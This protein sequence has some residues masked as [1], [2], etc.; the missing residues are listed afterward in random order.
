M[1]PEKT[2]HAIASILRNVDLTDLAD[3]ILSR[4]HLKRRRPAMTALSAI[5][6]MGLGAA[7]A[8]A[9]VAFVPAVRD[10]L[11]DDPV[12]RLREAV[13]DVLG[14]TEDAAL[15]AEHTVKRK[16][17][18]AKESA[19]GALKAQARASSNGNKFDV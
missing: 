16:V 5:G 17:H 8:L 2:T 15:E 13:D 4:V 10:A 12:G 14:A 19:K 18:E 6:W 1:N 7:G 11:S 9:V 3:G